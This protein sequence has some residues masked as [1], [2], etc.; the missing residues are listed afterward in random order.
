MDE[1]TQ[2]LLSIWG[3]FTLSIWVIQLNKQGNYLGI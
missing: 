3:V 1:A 2:L